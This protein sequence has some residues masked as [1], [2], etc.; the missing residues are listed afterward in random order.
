MN[1]RIVIVKELLTAYVEVEAD[2]DD[3]AIEDVKA[4]IDRGEVDV[5]RDCDD[6]S[7]TFE[8]GVARQE[9]EARIADSGTMFL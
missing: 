5:A 8:I 3:A 1:K 2:S 6:I 4:M 7:R 9:I